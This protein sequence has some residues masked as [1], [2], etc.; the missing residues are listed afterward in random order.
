MSNNIK[1]FQ[2]LQDRVVNTCNRYGLRLKIIN[3]KL[4]VSKQPH[5]HPQ[6]WSDSNR[7]Y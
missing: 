3:T 2:N 1:V 4:V 5:L 7:L 6:Q